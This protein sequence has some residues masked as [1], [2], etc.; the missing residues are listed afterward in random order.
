M[1]ELSALLALLIMSAFFS[2]SETA[3]LSMSRPRLD[4]L[5]EDGSE[6]EKISARRIQKLLTRPKRLLNAILLGNNL[7][8]TAIAAAAGALA[9]T[10]FGLSDGMGVLE[11]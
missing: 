1:L 5:A 2:S 8:N 9:T 7:V 3:F 4:H 6:K 10:V 11:T